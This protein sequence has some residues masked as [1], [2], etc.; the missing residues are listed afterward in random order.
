MHDMGCLGHA[1]ESSSTRPGGPNSVPGRVEG[2]HQPVLSCIAVFQ[3]H[4]FFPSLSAFDVGG[5]GFEF[6]VFVIGWSEWPFV[7][8]C[9]K[10]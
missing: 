8:Y 1:A 9:F 7:A 2:G 5:L 3:F 6:C 10:F 4:G